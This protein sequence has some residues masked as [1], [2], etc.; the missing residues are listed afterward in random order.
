MYS[1]I[2]KLERVEMELCVSKLN[3]FTRY[4][5][6]HLATTVVVGNHLFVIKETVQLEPLKD[7]LHSKMC[8]S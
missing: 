8:F 5:V 2:T 6:S 1:V 7:A 3:R 4:A